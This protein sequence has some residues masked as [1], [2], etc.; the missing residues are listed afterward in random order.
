ML[1]T[2]FLELTNHCNMNCDFCANHIMT[3]PRGY[4]SVELTTKIIDQLIEMDFKGSLIMSLMGEPLLHADFKG[5]LKYAVD[6]GIRTNVITNMSLIPEKVTPEEL[7][8]A[9]ID[10]LCISYQTP[11]KRTFELRRAKIS[12]ERYYDKL[13]EILA[14]ARGKQFNTFRIEIHI[15]QSFYNFL[16]VEVVNDYSLIESTAI[17]LYDILYPR[18]LGISETDFDKKMR[19][20]L[21]NFRHGNQYLDSFEIPIGQGIYVVL[22]RANTWA[23]CLIPEGCAVLPRRKG[24]C[25]FFHS[26]LGVLWDGRCTVCCQDF[27][28]H[29][30]VGDA[31]L[32]P[33]EDIWKSKRLTHMR[34]ME[35][36]GLMVNEYCQVC[37]G[38]IQK[39][40]HEFSVIKKHGVI[41]KVFQLINRGKVKLFK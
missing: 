14:Y 24:H 31:K 8:T 33:I 41:N 37:K 9:G 28:G 34:E 11:D 3:I 7:L 23:N 4:M 17:Q 39:N 20:A 21:R 15:L 6:S 36:K 12:F 35:K 16:N 18:N 22:K 30:F 27:N 5:I 40:G 10:T 2:V 29:I 25:G 38:K 32:S 13:K 1:T 26:S 19:S